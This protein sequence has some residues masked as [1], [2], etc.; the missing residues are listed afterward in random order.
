MSQVLDVLTD[1]VRRTTG[2]PNAVAR[3]GQVTFTQDTWDAMSGSGHVAAS[4]PVGLG[5]SF[6]TAVPA[7]LR[8]AQHGE[9]TLMSTESISLQTQLIE[10][11]LPVVADAV[12]AATGV[13]PRFAVYKG[14]S[15]TAC[16]QAVAAH[17]L[18][19]LDDAGVAVPVAAR[20]PTPQA[21]DVLARLLAKV[22]TAG[23][24]REPKTF[25][26]GQGPVPGADMVALLAWAA[27]AA[28]KTDPS[29]A[30]RGRYPGNL[31]DGAWASVS[32]STAE[33]IGVSQC[34]FA[35]M[36]APA[37]AR[38]R[39]A[40]ADVVVTNHH[41][42]AVQATTSAPVVI[43]NKTLGT[44]EHVVV[45][46][47]H[48]LPGIVRSAGACEISAR[49]IG[50]L[51]AGLRSLMDDGDRAVTRALDDGAVLAEQVSEVLGRALRAV[52]GP[53][54]VVR[55]GE[56]DD[57]LGGLGQAISGWAAQVG[58][59]VT[60]LTEDPHVPS[61]I[62]ARRMVARAESLSADVRTVTTHA[63]GVARWAQPDERDANL[64]VA[65]ASPVDVASALYNT[66]WT[67]PVPFD[68]DGAALVD[69]RRWVGPRMGGDDP[70]EELDDGESEQRYALSV[71]ACSGTMPAGYGAQAGLRA[72]VKDY[73]SP[74]AEAYSQ[75]LLYVPRA[76]DDQDISALC[77]STFGR[78][79]RL[80][81]GAH[82]AWAAA[83][84]EALVDASGGSALILAATAKAG[85]EYAR[86][87]RE[88]F[89]GR[90]N[91]L[92]QW[93]GR[94]A[95][96]LVAQW[97]ADTTSVLV[98]TRSLM[99]GTDAPGDTCQ[100]VVLD[101]IPRAAS[102]PVDDAR[103]ESAMTRAEVDRWAA[104]RWVYVTDASLLLEQAAG[105]LVRSAAD[106]G[107]VAV[108]DPRLLKV[109]PLSYPEPTRKVYLGALAAFTTRTSELVAATDHL[110][111]LD[112]ARR[113]TAPARAA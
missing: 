73:P 37:R 62:K 87:L 3:P 109:G 91:V 14:W 32:V 45:D 56:E 68:E 24:S 25:D 6:A 60:P 81:T 44:F 29:D 21:L 36:C 83:K 89:A 108:L 33:C 47:A 67:A 101:R 53:G 85:R 102:N 16:F 113:A 96:A 69:E 110:A 12:E 30:D 71:T 103:V 58:A 46:E 105:R 17:A 72:T 64:P 70:D 86:R 82:T 48:T 43:G 15:N 57:P 5:K 7:M 39:A 31:P 27:R 55:L 13:R 66:L 104:D 63:W 111:T 75:C 78:R 74:F 52:A 92:S 9:R 34:P 54:G 106:R 94:T 41:M 4:A 77:P 42:L 95:G 51:V 84:I 26:L 10:K 112:Q 80:E 99:T 79:P 35:D 98:G 11:D 19:L 50:S 100:L 20:Q 76:A 61:A 8:A 93:D 40:E 49:R 88:S 97:R 90:F 65:K 107:V 28:T 59:L 22:P 18:T 1:A 2:L 23:T 38:T